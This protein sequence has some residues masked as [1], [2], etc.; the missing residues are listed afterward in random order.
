MPNAARVLNKPSGDIFSQEAAFYQRFT[1]D[2]R[3]PLCRVI[4][5]R[6]REIRDAQLE[7][8]AQKKRA[9]KNELNRLSRERVKARKAGLS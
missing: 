3:G 2:T 9:H 1:D 5:R 8:F 6:M 7:L 4:L